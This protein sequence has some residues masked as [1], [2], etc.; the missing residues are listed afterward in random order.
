[1]IVWAGHGVTAA[2]DQT[3]DSPTMRDAERDGGRTAEI[4]VRERDGKSKN[5]SW[6]DNDK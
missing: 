3:D 5:L 4:L 2:A 6:N 1:M